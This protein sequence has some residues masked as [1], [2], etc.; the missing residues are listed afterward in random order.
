LVSKYSQIVEAYF[1]VP[2][3]PSGRYALAVDHG[4]FVRN[5]TDIRAAD[6]KL[7]MLL[8]SACDGADMLTDSL[9]ERKKKPEKSG[10]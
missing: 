10:F 1:A 3:R 9:F 2:G 8:N 5:L 6:K 4:A 7:N